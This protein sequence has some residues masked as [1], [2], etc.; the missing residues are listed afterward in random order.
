MPHDAHC[1]L[2]AVYNKP[3]PLATM[4]FAPAGASSLP[5]SI[6]PQPP[7]PPTGNVFTEQGPPR[8]GAGRRVRGEAWQR[9]PVKENESPREKTPVKGIPSP[10]GLTIR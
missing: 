2:T 10:S 4:P 9:V 5:H 6:L 8:Q 7:S 3:S 1:Q